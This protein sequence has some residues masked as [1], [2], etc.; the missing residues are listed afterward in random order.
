MCGVAPVGCATAT[1]CPIL[2]SIVLNATRTRFATRARHRRI[3]DRFGTEPSGTVRVVDL[4]PMR[5]VDDRE[6]LR[7]ALDRLTPRQR[8]CVV[9]R[10]WLGL[11]DVETAAAT[12]LSLG[13]VKPTYV[14]HSAHC[15]LISGRRGD[16]DPVTCRRPCP[17]GEP[18][19]LNTAT[20]ARMPV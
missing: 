9:C 4:D 10:Y 6:A 16:T 8:I 7:A 2:R 11:T 5:Q 14:G 19:L 13:T 17:G 1:G 3:T 20:N 18:C 15:A 12:G